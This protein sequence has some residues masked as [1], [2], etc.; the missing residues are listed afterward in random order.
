[1]RPERESLILGHAALI[2]RAAAP[3]IPVAFKNALLLIGSISAS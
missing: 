3:A 2:V 1:M